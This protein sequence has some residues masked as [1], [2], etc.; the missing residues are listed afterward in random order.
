MN[1]LHPHTW[2]HPKSAPMWLVALLVG[3]LPWSAT[4]AQNH[5]RVSEIG[6]FPQS[7]A[8]YAMG[9]SACFAGT[10]GNHIIMA[11]GCNFPDNSG[12]KHYYKGIYAACWQAD[13]LQWRCIGTLPE[14]VAYG[15]TV[16][17]G[18]SLLL[19]GGNN[20]EHSLR[21][22]VS[23]KLDPRGNA[24]VMRL[25]SLPVTVDNG[26]AAYAKGHVFVF[27]GNQNGKPSKAL[28]SLSCSRPTSQWKSRKAMPGKPRVQP[29]CVAHG[30]RLFAWGGFY[31]KGAKSK[32]ATDG[33]AYD[34]KR[35]RWAQLAAPRDAAGTQ[36]SHRRYQWRGPVAV[37]GRCEQDHFRR[38]HQWQIPISGPG[39]LP[40]ATSGVVSLQ[41]HAAR[42]QR[43]NAA[44]AETHNA[45][46]PTGKGG[47]SAHWH[48]SQPIPLYRRRTETGCQ[49]SANPTNRTRI[50][51]HT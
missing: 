19:I 1:N 9:V 46:R 32:V 10:I 11:G 47:R 17:M 50:N 21:Q 12:V 23:V 44:M 8:G 45:R 2:L 6:G 24:I 22:V 3:L 27:G 29:V 28:W 48:C 31:A 49:D 43:Q 5:L 35:N 37:P 36:R 15:A 18:D 16:D 40:Q 33:Y 14:P 41:C 13:T 20:Q 42:F 39:R 38:C 51:Q 4:M 30:Q 26:A 7:E 25:P 34:V